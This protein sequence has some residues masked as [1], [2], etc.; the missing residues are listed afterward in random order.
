LLNQESIS[1]QILQTFNRKRKPFEVEDFRKN[2]EKEKF[3]FRV[4]IQN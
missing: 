1:S 2:E 3:D 4:E